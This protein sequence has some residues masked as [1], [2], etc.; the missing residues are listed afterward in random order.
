VTEVARKKSSH[1]T[2]AELRLMEV[3][4]KKGTATVSDVV[5]A[6]ET[7]PPLAYSTV[8][9]TL[10]ILENKG[11]VRHT[12]DGRAFVYRPIVRRDKA[13]EGALKHLLRRFFEDS[14]ELLMLN[15]LERKKITPEELKRLRDRIEG[16]KS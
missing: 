3:L 11:Y 14:P 9:T 5:E 1:L 13:Q 8:L 10:R 12:K 2:D 7:E 6:L 15:L 4:W 16:K